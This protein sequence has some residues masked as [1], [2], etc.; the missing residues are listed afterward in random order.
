MQVFWQDLRYG[1][2]TVLKTPSFTSVAAL[3]LALCIGANTGVFSFVNALLLRQLE[4]AHDPA[5]LAQ[6]LQIRDG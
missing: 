6:V 2:R 4:G 3:T 5:A 1:L